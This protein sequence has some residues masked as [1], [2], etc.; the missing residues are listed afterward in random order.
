MAHDMLC[1]NTSIS[2]PSLPRP[3]CALTPLGKASVT[4]GNST[5][6]IVTGS[7]NA[8]VGFRMLIGAIGIGS[9]CAF[10]FLLQ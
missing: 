8:A 4:P 7:A 1:V 9:D 10:N 2:T 5:P 6:A 3:K